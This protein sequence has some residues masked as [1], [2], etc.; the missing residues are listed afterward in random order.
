MRNVDRQVED[1]AFAIARAFAE[2]TAQ[3]RAA[4]NADVRAQAYAFAEAEA[5]A[6]GEAVSG[7]FASSE[8]CGLCT[9]AIDATSRA[10]QELVALAVAEAWTEVLPGTPLPSTAGAAVVLE[11]P[12]LP[13]CALAS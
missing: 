4:G 9:A 6:I 5:R 3:C 11:E 1:V 13:G 8:V 2:V 10:T 7:I 12:S